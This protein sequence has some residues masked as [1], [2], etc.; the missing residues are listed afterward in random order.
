[1][2]FII[3]DL[4]W[5]G[6]FSKVVKR[7]FN[8]IIEIGAVMLDENLSVIGDFRRLIKPVMSNKLSYIVKQLTHI[9]TEELE[10][11][12]TFEKAYDDFS[13]WVGDDSV[14]LT[15]GKSDL[16]VMLEN[17]RYF[18]DSDIIPFL[19]R[20]A[21]LQKVTQSYLD[22]EKGEHLGLSKAAET[23]DIST[24]DM[25][26][27]RALEDSLLSAYIFQ[28][29]YA[30]VDL[31]EFMYEADKKEF[32]DRIEFKNT[33]LK[34][35]TNPLVDKK[36]LKFHCPECQSGSPP[37]LRMNKDSQWLFKSRAF[38]AVLVCKKCKNLFNARVQF[39]LTYDGIVISRSITELTEPPEQEQSD[40]N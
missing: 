18:I 30:S 27:H 1:M 2:R 23:L 22:C 36:Q 13:E 11:G 31:G 38:R 5:N 24:N 33:V 15:W 37:I 8:E 3:M 32:Y 16:L 9:T 4:E 29:V 25:E 40:Q 26:L 14:V 7:Y 20:Y 35:I 21:D 28:K 12:S 19:K 10:N 34:D 39:K 6:C 17:C